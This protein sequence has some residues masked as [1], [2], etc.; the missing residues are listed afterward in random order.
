MKRRLFSEGEEELI[1]LDLHW[2]KKN[3]KKW[4]PEH[5]MFVKC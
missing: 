3:S 5:L 2:L 1:N 4:I